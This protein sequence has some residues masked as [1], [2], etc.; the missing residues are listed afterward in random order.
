MCRKYYASWISIKPRIMSTVIF[1]CMGLV[2]NG[3]G[4][5][6]FAFLLLNIR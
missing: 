1:C 3:V 4:G 5:L 2:K 6:N